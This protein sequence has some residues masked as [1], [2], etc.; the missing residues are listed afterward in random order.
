MHF[1]HLISAGPFC[2]HSRVFWQGENYHLEGKRQMKTC[3]IVYAIDIPFSSWIRVQWWRTLQFFGWWI[4]LNILLGILHEV[5]IQR[6]EPILWWVSPVGFYKCLFGL[7]NVTW[8]ISLPLVYDFFLT[9]PYVL[10]KRKY[11]LQ[12]KILWSKH[13]W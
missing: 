11:Y 8:R 3:M 9:F 12:W 5:V 1:S 10:T 2:L 6:M 4:G 7:K 13:T